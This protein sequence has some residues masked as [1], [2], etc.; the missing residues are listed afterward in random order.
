MIPAS[1]QHSKRH[2]IVSRL[3]ADMH[4][5]QADHGRTKKSRL[6]GGVAWQAIIIARRFFGIKLETAKK[7]A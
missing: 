1:K 6:K 2:K 7:I 4:H 5:R 3:L